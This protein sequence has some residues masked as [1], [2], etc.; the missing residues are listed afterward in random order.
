MVTVELQLCSDLLISLGSTNGV[1]NKIDGLF[2]SGLVGDNAVVI[3]VADHRE[4][5]E[6]LAIITG[7]AIDYILYGHFQE[8]CSVAVRYSISGMDW[9][10]FLRN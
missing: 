7:Y 8:N 6:A 2:C 5:K 4:I 1:K 3:E 10:L 9:V